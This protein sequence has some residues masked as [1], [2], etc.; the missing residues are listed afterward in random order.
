MYENQINFLS[1]LNRVISGIESGISKIRTGHH[2]YSSTSE[3]MRLFGRYMSSDGRFV[4]VALET[5]ALA[6]KLRRRIM[7][8]SGRFSGQ[9]KGEINDELL[10]LSLVVSYNT[11]VH[12]KEMQPDHMV[13]PTLGRIS[14]VIESRQK[15]SKHCVKVINL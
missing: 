10:R 13:E 12:L 6:K 7:M 14:D 5:K 4:D 15:I 2:V 1:F 8:L 9:E 3:R 11:F